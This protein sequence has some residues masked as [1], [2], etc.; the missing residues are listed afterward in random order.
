MNSK[1]FEKHSFKG[2]FHFVLLKM[3]IYMLLLE[4]TVKRPKFG[5]GP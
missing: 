1:F 4:N 3:S 2:S 5:I